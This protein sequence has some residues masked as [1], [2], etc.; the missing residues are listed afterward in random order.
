MDL[1]NLMKK[2]GIIN[3]EISKVLSN[4]RH[5]DLIC[6]SDLGLPYPN[7]VKTIDLSLRFGL[8]SFIDVLTEITKDMKIERIIL[9][10]EIK[11]NNREIYDEILNMFENISI[12]YVSHN[13]FKQITSDCKAIIRTGEATPYAN[14]ILQSACIF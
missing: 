2:N 3:S 9:A 7:N 8:P 14:I 5:T 1:I 6:I 4:M 11:N 13:N 12:E 10:E